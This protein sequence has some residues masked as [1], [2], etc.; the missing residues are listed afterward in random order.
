[1]VSSMTQEIS[2]MRQTEIFDPIK[3]SHQIVI[4]GAGSI[5]SFAALNLAKIGFN[6]IVVYDFDI[7]ENYNLPNQFYRFQDIGKFKVDA[8]KEII[9]EFTNVEIETRNEKVDYKTKLNLSLNNLYIL[10]FDTL[11][12]RKLVYDKLRNFNNYLLD[13]RMGGEE[14]NIITT[15]MNDSDDL[16]IHDKEFEITPTELRC[17]E[18]SIIYSV[19]NISSEVCN[20]VKKIS[21]NQ[22]IPQKITRSMKGYR[23]LESR[24]NK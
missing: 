7:I 14:W 17:G 8:L 23:I 12:S 2:F 4:F 1:M 9:K 24:S 22:K 3:Q 20:L 6:N 10:T 11:E 5:G 18:K 16:R 21:L 13:V 19:L 15:E